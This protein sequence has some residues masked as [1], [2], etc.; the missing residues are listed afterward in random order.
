MQF[1]VFFL[2]SMQIRQMHFI[3]R[4]SFHCAVISAVFFLFS[5]H[6]GLNFFPRSLKQL[7]DSLF[8]EWI[9][10][11]GDDGAVDYVFNIRKMMCE[12]HRCQ[13]TSE[14]SFRVEKKPKEKSNRGSA[15]HS[16]F[17]FFVLFLILRLHFHLLAIKNYVVAQRIGAPNDCQRIANAQRQVYFSPAHHKT[18]TQSLA[19]VSLC[20]WKRDGRQRDGTRWNQRKMGH[21]RRAATHAGCREISLNT[22]LVFFSPFLFSF[23][24]LLYFVNRLLAFSLNWLSEKETYVS[25]TYR[26]VPSSKHECERHNNTRSCASYG[27][28]EEEIYREASKIEWI[29]ALHAHTHAHRPD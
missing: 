26:R 15:V 28:A 1:F 22:N 3:G 10:P 5:I 20:E 23:H 29:Y 9:F 6:L 25:W 19:V 27:R 17:F 2:F 21:R 24:I 8:Q 12:K 11:N 4:F 16:I 7:R 14:K 13:S 18:Y